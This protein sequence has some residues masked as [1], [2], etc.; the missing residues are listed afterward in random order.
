MNK[1]NQ[2][3]V[4]N[5][6]ALSEALE[7][8]SRLAQINRPILVIGERGTGKELLAERIHYLSMRWDQPLLKIN[9]AA[10]A[11]SLLESELFGHEPGAF[12]GATRVHQ[13]RFERA[14]GGTLFLDELANMSLGLQE[15]LLRVIEYGEFERLGGQTT[16]HADVRVVAATNADLKQLARDSRFRA[17]L[18]DRLSFDVVHVPPLHHREGDI[19]ELAY[20]F[21]VHMCSELGWEA[22]PGFT[23]AAAEQLL[24]HPWPGNVRELKNVVERSLY[25]WGDASR[26]VADIVLDPF[27]S[28]YQGLLEPDAT[29]GPQRPENG[30]EVSTTGN[31]AIEVA[32]FEIRLLRAALSENHFHQGATAT[33]LGLSYDQLRGLLRKYKLS[34]ERERTR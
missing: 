26:P 25:R 23:E 2:Q 10:I 27:V 6:P 28:P 20:H 8:A 9:C 24:H 4:G 7:Q 19:M 5:S 18:L 14:A 29:T 31:F 17:D 11:E 16:L 13:G 3:V 32:A 30:A 12:T 21:A 34:R 1:E 22:F 33:A 15:K